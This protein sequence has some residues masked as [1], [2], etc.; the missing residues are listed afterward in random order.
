MPS[1]RVRDLAAEP[2]LRLVQ[3]TSTPEGDE[4]RVA[5]VA[6]T[7]LP[8]PLPFLRGGELVMTTGMLERRDDE[9]ADL[10]TR[11]AEL[12]V[13]ALCFG[14][15]LV[16]D[17]VPEALVGAARHTGLTLLES[18]VEVPFVQ[19][20]RWVADRIFAEQYAAVQQGARI[21]DELVADLLSG[22]GLEAL[23]RRL[24]ASLNA[25]AV[26]L[27]EPDGR[28]IARQPR[29]A[30]RSLPS[31]GTPAAGTP[32]AAPVTD[33]ADSEP[34]DL[35]VRLGGTTVA[36]LRAEHPVAD[37][38]LASFAVNALGLELARR[39]AVRTG[40]RELLGQVLEDI[41][42]RTQSASEARRRLQ[43]NGIDA[44]A[45]HRVVVARLDT[46]PDRLRRMPWALDRP[47][48]EELDPQPTALVQGQPFV[49]LPA[50]VDADE[51]TAVLAR[52]LQPLDPRVGLGISQPRE[53]TSGIRVGYFEARHAARRGPGVQHAE[54]LTAM[55]LLLG[56][57]DQPLGDV[58][59]NLLA[60]LARHDEE[61]RSDLVRTLRSFLAHDGQLAATAQDLVVHRNTLRYRLQQVQMLTGLDLDRLTDRIELWFALAAVDWEAASPEAADPASST[62][63]GRGSGRRTDVT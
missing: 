58:G 56:N 59:R 50:T 57:L 16:H 23:L 26:S 54:P 46:T 25:G 29:R 47:F 5:W 49:L 6:T 22:G 20:S 41:V 15:G 3:H 53:G 28:L 42:L 51:V 4:R 45:P 14:T 60:P 9:W 21:Q 40:R 36:R 39:Q 17:E 44:T 8:D 34:L 43:L 2:T 48:G 30:A 18:P 1:A 55:G 31:A 37:L 38:G 62:D 24:R 33:G 11:L 7:E 32:S 12:P 19:I 35:P 27:V 52:H 13:A 10:A 61:H 63:S